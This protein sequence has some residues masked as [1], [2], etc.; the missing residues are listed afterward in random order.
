MSLLYIPPAAA[1]LTG[2]TLPSNIV[3]SSLTSV[4]TLTSLATSGAITMA[5]NVYLQGKNTGGTA[6]GIATVDNSDTLIINPGGD[7]P[8]LLAGTSTKVAGAFYIPRQ[9]GASQTSVGLLADTGVPSN[10]YGA[11]GWYYF[12]SGGVAGSS[13]YKK[14]SGAWTALA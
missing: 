13:I 6:K 9:D 14:L 4:G 12:R 2:T 7:L 5:N 10:T 1:N 3:A 8:I 11:D